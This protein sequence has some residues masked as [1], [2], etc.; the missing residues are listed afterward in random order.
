VERIR[1]LGLKPS[2]LLPGHL[3]EGAG[4]LETEATVRPLTAPKASSLPQ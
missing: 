3:T 2:K 1:E 4:E